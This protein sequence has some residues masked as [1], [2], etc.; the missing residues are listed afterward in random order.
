M[1]KIYKSMNGRLLITLL[2]A[3]FFLQ[4]CGTPVTKRSSTTTPTTTQ[5]KAV[6]VIAE[7]ELT[8]DDLVAEAAQHDNEQATIL[9][10][11]A[12]SKYLQQDELNKALFISH[13]VSKM[14]LSVAQNNYNLLNLA[15]AL[16]E[17]QLY[18]LA[19]AKLTEIDTLTAGNRQLQLS[20]KINVKRG[21]LVAAIVDYLKYYQQNPSTDAEQLEYLHSL[22]AQLK[23]W[24][25]KALA[26]RQDKDLKGWL[27]FNQQ[28]SISAAKLEDSNI[29]LSR[30]QK[31]YPNH[32]ANYLVGD[33]TDR[34]TELAQQAEIQKVS[35]LIPLS[36]REA[37]LGKTLQ[38][39]I[40][41]AYQ[42]DL[43]TRE[44]NF[45]DTNKQAMAN[46]ITELQLFQ[47]DFVIG[48]LLKHHVDSYLAMTNTEQTDTDNINRVETIPASR[49]KRADIATNKATDL[50]TRLQQQGLAS[51]WP[52]LLLNLPEQG[53]LASHH[54]ALSM[55]P[56]DEASQA[57]FSLS[58]KG[59]QQ[60]LI[61][62]QNTA[63][64]K[65]MANSFAQQWQLQTGLAPTIV[66]YPNGKKMQNSIKSGLDVNLSDERIFLLRNRL[67]ENLKTETRN[68]RD[69]DLIYMFATPDQA[70][71][72]KPYIDVNTSPF[73]NAIPIYA[74]SRSNS[75][76]ADRN[77]RRDL[78]GLTF[79]EIP[80]LLTG[81]Q[82][83]PDLS[84]QAK[85]LWPTRSSALERIY[86]MGIDSWQLTSKVNSM[87]LIPVLKHYGETGVLQM[88]QQRIINRSL[89]WGRYRSSR[90]QNVEM[91]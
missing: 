48:P 60:A 86:A 23:P 12:A 32:P 20:A 29:N 71:L 28:L 30:W 9:L 61:L 11:Q 49:S 57:A 41:A 75:D 67:Q 68:R 3:L 10:L 84:K 59:F 13:E 19:Y 88:N 76:Q 38:A 1:T 87:K 25:T 36:G 79:T 16:Y 31:Q 42:Q 8:A 33:F 82:N 4:S 54:F 47:P 65:R 70:R 52:T 37:A 6:E 58:K 56:E 64:G 78:N 43:S 14:P 91:D 5:D 62:S 69:I 7:S 18:D 34:T 55:L 15:S 27:A 53:Q 66:Y 80:W 85:Q 26:K 77:T 40:L 73:A 46:I 83:N 51:N 81:K 45:I 24:Q 35:V 22:F 50:T 44:I 72:L 74:S 39:G 2:C 17:L 63:I 21:L 89:L 90:I